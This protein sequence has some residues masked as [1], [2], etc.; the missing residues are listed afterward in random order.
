MDIATSHFAL[1]AREATFPLLSA[2][3]TSEPR[4]R[5]AKTCDR[6]LSKLECVVLFQVLKPWNPA[7]RRKDP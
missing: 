5:S 6:Q 4:H 1:E 7:A 2:T 3:L